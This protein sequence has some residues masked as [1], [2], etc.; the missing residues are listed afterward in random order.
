VALVKA[1]QN[2][3]LVVQCSRAGSGRIVQR[4]EDRDAGFVPADNLNP[5]KAR[6]LAM[7]ALAATTERREIT[8][9]FAEY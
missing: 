3:I 4:S 2:G 8:R 7:V 6:V 9:M 1:A 5:Q